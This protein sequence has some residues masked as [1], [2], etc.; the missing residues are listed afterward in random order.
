MFIL[1]LRRLASE[2]SRA[3]RRYTAALTFQN[4]QTK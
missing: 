2:K 1:M 3:T 4:T